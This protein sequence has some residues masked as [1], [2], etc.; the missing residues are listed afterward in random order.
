MALALGGR[1][2]R[3]RA[4]PALAAHAS[5]AM[6]AIAFAV[7]TVV[8]PRRPAASPSC[9]RPRTSCPR[10]RAHALG[11][12]PRDVVGGAILLAGIAAHRSSPRRPTAGRRHR[13]P[14]RAGHDEHARPHL[15]VAGERPRAR[16]RA[17]CGCSSASSSPATCTTPSPTTCRRSRSRRRPASAVAPTDPAAA[18]AVLRVIEGEASRTLDEMRS[19]VRVLRQRRRRRPSVA[20]SRRASPICARLAQHRRRPPSS[21]CRSTAMSTTVPP[22]VARPSSGSP[23]R[24]SP[25]RA[26][27]RATPPGS[28]CACGVDAERHAARRARRRR[29]PRHPR[30]RLRHHRHARARGSARRHLRGRPARRA[31][32]GPSPP[33]CPRTGGRHERPRPH[34]R[35]PGARAHRAAR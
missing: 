3:A 12:R 8:E 15:P 28:T 6:L 34:R 2:R 18:A 26:A 25:T 4:D 13:R 31:A 10:L 20:P 16:A 30:A 5:A 33:C 27:T 24:P 1:A 22:P 19:M 23:R 7:G 32:A 21:T 14:R 29:G 11:H 17:R 9:S 35:R